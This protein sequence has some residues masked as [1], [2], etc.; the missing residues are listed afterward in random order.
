MLNLQHFHPLPGC[1]QPP[2]QLALRFMAFSL[3][4]SYTYTHMS[5]WSP[6]SIAFM[7]R[8]DHFRLD[9]LLEG[10][11]LEKTQLPAHGS[12]WSP[13]ILHLGVGPCEI[14]SISI[15]MSTGDVITLVLSQWPSH[16]DLMGVAFIMG[17]EVTISQQKSW[18]SGYYNFYPIFH[19]VPW[20][21]HVGVVLYIFD[22]CWATRSQFSAFWPV[23]DFCKGLWHYAA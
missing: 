2:P 18:I 4:T 14:S 20:P 6:F 12:H 7:F 9:N 8:V 10:W 21:L 1:P 19:N 13:T 5:I 22:W 17:I 16:W 15:G 23:G 11:S 3:I